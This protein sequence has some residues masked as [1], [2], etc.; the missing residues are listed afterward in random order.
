MTRAKTAAMLRR[1]G[2][3]DRARPAVNG[4]P[5]RHSMFMARRRVAAA[6]SERAGDWTPQKDTLSREG[7]CRSSEDSTSRRRRISLMPWSGGTPSRESFRDGTEMSSSRKRQRSLLPSPAARRRSLSPARKQSVRR[8]MRARFRQVQ[9]VERISAANKFYGLPTLLVVPN[10]E[11]TLL[12]VLA[13]GLMEVAVEML[14]AYFTQPA[15]PNACGGLSNG[16]VGG[17]SNAT[18]NGTVCVNPDEG[19]DGVSLAFAWFALSLAVAVGLLW[20][21][22]WVGLLL[23]DFRRH[24]SRQCWVP[25]AEI[26]ETDP[27]VAATTPALA[28]GVSRVPAL[29]LGNSSKAAAPAGNV[30][31]ASGG[32]EARTPAAAEPA[33]A[34]EA[35]KEEKEEE[36]T[37]V[38]RIEEA[39]SDAAAAAARAAE[40]A[41][42]AAARAAEEMA[43]DVAE[44]LEDAKAEVFEEVSAIRRALRQIFTARRA[45]RR[46][47]AYER[48]EADAAEPARTEAAL[49]LVWKGSVCRLPRMERIAASAGLSLD[50]L[51]SFLD[52]GQPSRRG[53]YHTFLMMLLQLTFA[54][55]VGGFKRPGA[56]NVSVAV[57]QVSLL[58]LMQLLMALW[59]VC[60][61]P[62]DKLLGLTGFICSLFELASSC[63]LL[64]AHYTPDP[65]SAARMGKMAVDVF[66]VAIFTPLALALNDTLVV[67]VVAAANRI[68]RRGRAEHWPV[69]RILLEVLLAL[70]RLPLD[71]LVEVIGQVMPWVS[72]LLFKVEEAEM[73]EDAERAKGEAPATAEGEAPAA[74]YAPA[75]SATAA[76]VAATEG[77][78][79]RTIVVF[80]DV[81]EARAGTD[82][83]HARGTGPL[84]THDEVTEC[85]PVPSSEPLDV[86]ESGI[87]QDG[88][89][90]APSQASQAARAV[91]KDGHVQGRLTLARTVARAATQGEAADG[92]RTRT[93]LDVRAE[94]AAYYPPREAVSGGGGGAS[95][96]RSNPRAPASVALEDGAAADSTTPGSSHVTSTS[97]HIQ[98]KMPRAITRQ[99]M[100]HSTSET[101]S[102]RTER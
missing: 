42:A 67:P 19:S 59:A 52:A 72:F 63:M 85:A 9:N 73:Q 79:T 62:S 16:T 46:A 78:R 26:D 36:E 29:A 37:M 54:S 1:E 61:D 28:H 71:F 70:L 43:E 34:Q 7:S 86:V 81:E 89:E 74:A 69:R 30:A 48:P 10:L 13:A 64:A 98:S 31:L 51:M 18:A 80:K 88:L 17:G 102:H 60:G 2:S 76:A 6:D 82:S 96:R 5:H 8:I 35:E 27:A 41:A 75:R 23:H 32:S 14:V 45:A 39:V 4:A 55:L 66:K 40:E 22:L 11:L 65:D 20:W 47:G 53:T 3:L 101:S 94:L 90:Q 95:P 84:V 99:H 44:L 83:A 38:E 56:K 92:F 33:K 58:A 49:S 77:A 12:I 91:S 21:M 57:L 50:M 100:N 93:I 15:P 97:G 25:A 24:H 68:V 87:T